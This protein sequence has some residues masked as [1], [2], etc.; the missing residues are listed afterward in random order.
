LREWTNGQAPSE[1]LAVQILLFNGYEDVDPSHPLGGQDG[2]QDILC[3][4][5]G[6]RCLAAVYFPRGQQN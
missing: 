6:L 4:N 3:A 5:D 2:G 1:R